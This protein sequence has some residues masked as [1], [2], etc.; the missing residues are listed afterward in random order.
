MAIQKVMFAEP[1]RDHEVV[2]RCRTPEGEAYN[3]AVF[4]G[5]REECEAYEADSGKR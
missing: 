3:R 4:T 1:D 2:V 5:S